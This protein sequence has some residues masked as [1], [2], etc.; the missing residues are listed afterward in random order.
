MG[1]GLAP[2]SPEGWAVAAVAIVLA[3]V[4]GVA[5]KRHWWVALIVVVV[6]IAVTFLKGTSPGGPRQWEEFQASRGGRG[7][8]GSYGG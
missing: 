2:V 7:D 5:D 3:V 4:L 8:S 6:L 1:W